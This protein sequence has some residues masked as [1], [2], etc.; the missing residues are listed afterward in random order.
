MSWLQ[1]PGW[2][3]ALNT[4]TWQ[5][6]SLHTAAQYTNYSMDVSAQISEDRKVVVVR[7]ANNAS[8]EGHLSIDFGR[9]LYQPQDSTGSVGASN[10]DVRSPVFVQ[11]TQLLGEHAGIRGANTPSEPLKVSPVKA[12]LANWSVVLIPPLSYNIFEFR[13]E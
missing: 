3:H 10:T 4:D 1:P 11:L 9:R 6:L 7:V 5:P 12:T 13:F 2:V 8:D